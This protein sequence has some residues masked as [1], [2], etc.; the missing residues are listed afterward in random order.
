MPATVQLVPSSDVGVV[1]M[2]VQPAR[3]PAARIRAGLKTA[4]AFIAFPID[5]HL[6]PVGIDAVGATVAALGMDDVHANA[7]GLIDL[8]C[9]ADDRLH[10]W[11][12]NGLCAWR[13]DRK[14][15]V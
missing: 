12:K 7:R 3:P 5:V 8:A 14:S 9:K 11:L 6:H 10:R 1:D 15:V 2:L 4:A 13:R